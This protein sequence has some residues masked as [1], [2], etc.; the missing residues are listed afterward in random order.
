MRR[1]ETTVWSREAVFT[2]RCDPSLESRVV[3]GGC[4]VRRDMDIRIRGGRCGTD[5]RREIGDGGV[6]FTS[7]LDIHDFREADDTFEDM[8]L[9]VGARAV[10]YED[11]TAGVRVDFAAVAV[12]S[13]GNVTCHALH[14]GGEFFPSQAAFPAEEGEE[15]TG[16]HGCGFEFGTVAFAIHVLEFAADGGEDG[17]FPGSDVFVPDGGEERDWMEVKMPADVFVLQAGTL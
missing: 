16:D 14:F 1:S 13:E 3:D 6:E 4:G 11:V 9:V 10:V 2:Q 12:A 17:A 8:F 7:S 5:E 15:D